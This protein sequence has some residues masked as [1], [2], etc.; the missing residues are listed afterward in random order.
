MAP[1]RTPSSGLYPISIKGVTTLN[2]LP[3]TMAVLALSLDICFLNRLV[4][5]WKTLLFSVSN[6][7]TFLSVLI[8]LNCF[9]P[10]FPLNLSFIGVFLLSMII[11]SSPRP[12]KNLISLV[13]RGS[14][15]LEKMAYFIL[16]FFESL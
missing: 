3:G 14:Y 7:A 16:S 12:I 1:R 5:P 4:S 15:V 13:K 2:K 6:T 9:G 8:R 10:S 11:L